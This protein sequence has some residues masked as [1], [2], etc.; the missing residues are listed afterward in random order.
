[1]KPIV[2]TAWLDEHREGSDIVLADVRWKPNEVR[3][4]LNAFCE[5]H[6]PGAVFVDLDDD[7]SDRSDLSRGR[8]PLPEASVFCQRMAELGIGADTTVIAYDDVSGG[9]AGRLWWMLRWVGHE[10][11][12][13]LDGGYGKWCRE[14]RSVEQGKSVEPKLHPRPIVPRLNDDMVLATKD[15]VR[16]ALADGWVLLDARAG[17]RFRGEVEPID[18]HAGH[19]PGA[20]SAPFMGNLSGDK[21]FLSAGDLR[22]RF[23]SMG[24]GEGDRVACSCGS[25]ITA[26]HDIIAM[27]L[28]GFSMPRLYPGSWSEW[29]VDP[30]MPTATGA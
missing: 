8:H 17:E 23:E 12:A 1:M 11:V 21:T 15:A 20:V 19:I 25:G 6:V 30:D 24:I 2:T 29:S 5:G 3:A 26:C 27:V 22:R 18:L 7:L 13:I 14:G 28:A 9:L 4:G 10:N 16:N